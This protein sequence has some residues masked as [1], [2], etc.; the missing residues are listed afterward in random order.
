[1][2]KRC[3]KFLISEDASL[4][5]AFALSALPLFAVLGLSVDYTS[6][7]N[8]KAEMQNA[9]D[10][11]TLA[12]TTLPTD[13]TLAKRQ[14]ALQAF[15]DANRGDGT[16][17]LNSFTV[18]L[19]GTS[20]A[21]S[22]A[23]FN[24]PTNF[25]R[26][27]TINTVTINVKSAATKTPAL[28]E[29]TF[30]ID[31]ASG[32]WNKKMTLFGT[33]FGQTT[34]KALMLIDYKYNGGGGTKGYGTTVVYTPDNLGKLTVVQQT[35][36]CVTSAYNSWSNPLK[37][38]A[39][40]DGDKQV[41]CTTTPANGTGAVIDVK[42]MEKL[43]L[44]MDVPSGNPKV[45][46]SNDPAT[47]NRLY[48][49]GVEVETGK[50]VDIFRAVPCGNTSSQAWEDGGNAVPAPVSNADFFYTVSGKCEFSQKPSTTAL[51]Q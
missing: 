49:D 2:R 51:T 6:G 32:Y 47:S 10:A 34:E 28:V 5:P 50:T 38:G 19:D 12:I 17:T 31:K 48:L 16:A 41:L 4:V 36:T 33:A 22:S 20:R 15:Y 35:Q 14:E 24:M 40:V 9:L 1:M 45:L 8:S 44:Q 25:M 46:K 7:V 27:A 29:A 26:L 23:S 42:T 3:L 37:P 11:A 30:K 18:D 21:Q 43:Y 39:F 13:T